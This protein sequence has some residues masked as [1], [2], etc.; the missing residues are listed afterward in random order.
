MLSDGATNS[1]MI[2]VFTI[3]NVIWMH[4]LAQET[5]RY[6]FKKGL[7]HLV[8]CIRKLRVVE[9]IV[10]TSWLPSAWCCGLLDFFLMNIYVECCSEKCVFTI[11]AFVEHSTNWL[12][13]EP[14]R[15]YYLGNLS[16]S[17][18]ISIFLSIAISISISIS[19]S[20]SIYIYIYIH[21]PFHLQIDIQ[22][23][24]KEKLT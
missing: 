3:I 22:S 16:L 5:H 4:A 17:L 8:P 18:S 7:G 12:G 10:D 13:I 20:A 15:F 19:I 23:T 1:D 11:P 9:C 2:N 21:I 14:L 6:A 24:E